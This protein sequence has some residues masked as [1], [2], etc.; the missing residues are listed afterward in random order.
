MQTPIKLLIMAG[1]T[2][3]HI[4]PGLA[5]A[6]YV[7][8]RGVTVHWL[9]TQKGL[10]SELVPA[11]GIPISFIPIQ[12]VRGKN[13]KTKL[14]TPV[15][16]LKAVMQAIRI[17]HE[18]QP[19][20]VIGFGG[21][22][23]GPGA[24]ASWLLRKKLVI[25]EQNA[26]PGFTNRWL[27]HLADQVFEGFP[28][29]FKRRKNVVTVGNP[30]RASIAGLPS[31]TQ[32]F[33]SRDPSRPMRLL[34][35]GGSLG[36]H[37]LNAVMP[38]ALA[39]L[40][41]NERPEIVHQTGKND[42]DAIQNAYENLGV[43]ARVT[44]FIKE[45]DAVYAWADFVVCRAGALTIAELCAAGIGAILV[46]YPHAVDDHQTANALFLV[47]HQAACL[48][49]Q[50]QLNE[51][52]LI[53]LLKPFCHSFTERLRFAENAYPLRQPDPCEKIWNVCQEILA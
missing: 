24:I 5:L 33:Q 30:V 36:A 6:D 32:R 47:N 37:A 4:F 34:I 11:A 42:C 31:P 28:N 17:I 18:I 21:F 16:L 22:A 20:L 19:D 43:S 9:G 49:P 15:Y 52:S 8:A 41:P 26:I 44:P 13:W 12:G 3:G 7:R 51:Q 29:T 48:L 45:M 14:L 2:G 25:H 23:S 53:A 50:S 1:G 27:A 46:P 40:A 38:Q 35:L 39:T 10:E